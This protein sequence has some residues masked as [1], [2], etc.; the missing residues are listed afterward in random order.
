MCL[1]P[2]CSSTESSSDSCNGEKNG[3]TERRVVRDRRDNLEHGSL[4]SDNGGNCRVENLLVLP[5]SELI[6]QD[7][8]VNT[9]KNYTPNKINEMSFGKYLDMTE[10]NRMLID[11]LWETMD[12]QDQFVNNLDK[13]ISQI[14]VTEREDKYLEL[15]YTVGQL[16][17]PVDK[18]ALE[19]DHEVGMEKKKLNESKTSNAATENSMIR[20]VGNK[21][22]VTDVTSE[23][24]E[25]NTIN[26]KRSE[27]LND[28]KGLV[29]NMRQNIFTSS[30]RSEDFRKKLLEHGKNRAM[31]R[32]DNGE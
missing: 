1:A 23:S 12:T 7:I 9:I 4:E 6:C 19:F 32:G 2:M 8:I 20:V 11:M 31:N 14:D 27:I 30:R 18:N 22:E 28:I 29:S 16:P 24:F 25:Q 26:S 10:G 21:S 13:M 5:C 15:N 3:V 17:S